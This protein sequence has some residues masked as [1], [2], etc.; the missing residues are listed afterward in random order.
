MGELFRDRNLQLIT[1]AYAGLGYFQYIFFYWIYYYF[2]Q[3]RRLPAHESAGYTTILFVVEGVMMPLGGLVSDR[4][5]RTRGAQFGRRVVPMVG[6]TLSAVC[7]YLGTIS[8]ETAAV[9][10][11]LS[12]AFGFAAC[13]EG[14][15]WAFLTDAAGQN[16][17]AAS[18]IL[19]TG[20]QVGGFFSP[21]VTPYIAARM[22][23]SWGL[24]VGSFFA[25]LGVIALYFVRLQ[26]SNTGAGSLVLRENSTASM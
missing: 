12:L 9:V 23:W 21:M 4:V 6:L 17:G 14:P 25:I 22:G 24:Y 3:V 20:A 10:L 7:T 11:F 2:D 5:T 18:S 8:Y 26:I 15:F 16:V 19:N 1:F 13:C